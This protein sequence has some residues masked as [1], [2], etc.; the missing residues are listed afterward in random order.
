MRKMIAR[1]DINSGRSGRTILIASA[2]SAGITSA[3]V[4]HIAASRATAASTLA[5]SGNV[6]TCAS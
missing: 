6:L 2:P 1:P 4:I 3:H 5:F